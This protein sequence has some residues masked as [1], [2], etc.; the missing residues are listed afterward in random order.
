MRF[1]I[2]ILLLVSTYVSGQ[3]IIE[4]KIDKFDKVRRIETDR[5][6]VRQGLSCGLGFKLRSVD[7]SY[8][9]IASG[10]ACAVGVVGAHDQMQ[11]LLDN[12]ST[13][14]VKSTGLQSYDVSGAQKSYSHQYS[15]TKADLEALAAFKIKSVRRYFNSNYQDIDIS[16][17]STEKLKRLSTVFL[18]AVNQKQ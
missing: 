17:G 7:D 18:N 4:N 9:I 5:I 14:T 15:I 2:I 6:F 16:G 10:Y 1:L 13:L 8:Y 12:D 3:R 11:I